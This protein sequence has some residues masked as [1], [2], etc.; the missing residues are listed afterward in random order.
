GSSAY[1]FESAYDGFTCWEKIETFEPDLILIDLMLP[2][3]HGMEIL[4]KIKTSPRTQHIGVFLS[5]FC[6]SA[7]NYHSALMNHVDYFLEKPFSS[8][9]LGTLFHR[10]FQG[11][12]FPS[13]FVGM[14]SQ[15]E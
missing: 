5:S 6:S 8:T 9:H 7:Q 13:P 15:V 11:G 1:Q 14:S 4:R 12:L 2:Q 10:Y 3:I